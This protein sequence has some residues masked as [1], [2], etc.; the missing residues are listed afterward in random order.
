MRISDWSSDV[1]SSDLLKA[2]GRTGTGQIMH[3]IIDYHAS[4]AQAADSA[5][6]AGVKMLVLS[7]VVPPLP[8]R[9]FDAA[10]LDGAKGHFDGPLIIGE[11]GQVYS[12]TA[13]STAIERDNWFQYQGAVILTDEDC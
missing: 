2:A 7:H 3:D 13:G 9:Y 12:L 5:R 6:R 8:S 10:F 4:P 11:D 1:C